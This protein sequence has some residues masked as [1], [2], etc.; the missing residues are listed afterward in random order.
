MQ[1]IQRVSHYFRILFQLIFIVI[2]LVQIVGWSY[3]PHDYLFGIDCFNVI[4]EEYRSHIM[5]SSFGLDTKILGFMLDMVPASFSLL[6]LYFLVRLFK[7]Y[8]VGEIFSLAN[9]GYLRKI[10][11]ALLISQL[12]HPF[13]E[14]AMG[15]VV[16]WPNPAGQ[17][18]R[19]AAVTIGTTNLGILIMGALVILV[20]WIMAE[21]YKLREEQQLTV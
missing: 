15:A 13:Y 1:K 3:A 5:V 10:G 9:V 12:A 14:F 20:S 2:P 17:H 19:Y 7:L 11:Y 21:G 8:E 16:T 6:I 4:P 18:Q